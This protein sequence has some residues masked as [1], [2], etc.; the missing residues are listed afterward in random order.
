MQPSETLTSEPRSEQEAAYVTARIN[1]LTRNGSIE[2]LRKEAR[3]LREK[4]AN[5]I[6]DASVL[7]TRTSRRRLQT[8]WAVAQLER[9]DAF[10]A[11]ADRLDAERPSGAAGLAS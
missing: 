3:K 5:G 9:A 10:D 1:A 2:E 11:E 8:K 7:D 4:V 6:R